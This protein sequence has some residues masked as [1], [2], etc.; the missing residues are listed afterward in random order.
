MIAFAPIEREFRAASRQKRLYK[1]RVGTAAVFGLGLLPALGTGADGGGA[2]AFAWLAVMVFIF[3]S[4]FAVSQTCGTISDEQRQGTLGLL[5]LTPLRSFDVVF[6]KFVAR[7]CESLQPC[8]VA[9]PMIFV[10]FAM[11][12]LTAGQIMT[13]FVVILAQVVLCVSI[14]LLASSY[15]KD[16]TN[17]F[18][19]ATLAIMS[20]EI[21]GMIVAHFLSISALGL[22]FPI[23]IEIG[24]FLNPLA[25]MFRQFSMGPGDFTWSF[26]T[27]GFSVLLTL[28]MLGFAAARIPH[29][30]L[31]DFTV[32]RWTGFGNARPPRRS[33]CRADE[34]SPIYWLE[35][36]RWKSRQNLI[37]GTILLTLSVILLSVNF[38]VATGIFLSSGFLG[39]FL[40]SMLMLVSMTRKVHVQKQERT[41]E[42]IFTAPISERDWIN[43]QL[44]AAWSS[45]GAPLFFCGILIFLG[46]VSETL[47]RQ[48]DLT[49]LI[50]MGVYFGIGGIVTWYMMATLTLWFGLTAKNMGAAIG[51]VILICLGVSFFCC[52]PI[53]P[54]LI[55][56][57]IAHQKLKNN[58]RNRIGG[59]CSLHLS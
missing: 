49:N 7:S 30:V 5:L 43:Q 10:P 20:F 6:A 3:S 51:S 8:L 38:S 39:Y 25:I 4:F 31:T 32:R 22:K 52:I 13:A 19:A 59:A 21:P 46:F 55:A 29:L 44:K 40:L 11:G 45:Y 12:G 34:K 42:L 33:R 15:S 48:G 1:M 26:V 35:W 54:Q 17:A 9:L 56:G 58:L 47:S 14:T 37:L 16:A 36:G 24:I 57:H 53:L 23:L 27:L 28:P 2:A 41:L 18:A 50:M